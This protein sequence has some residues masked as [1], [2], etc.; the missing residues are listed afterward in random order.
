MKLH[1][2]LM[3]IAINWLF[4]PVAGK[5]E[6]IRSLFCYFIMFACKVKELVQLAGL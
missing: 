1:L 2:I 3:L 5:I 4:D 6:S